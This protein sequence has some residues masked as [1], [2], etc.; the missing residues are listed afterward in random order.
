ML[1]EHSARVTVQKVIEIG[2]ELGLQVV[3]E[4]VESKEQLL[5][6]QSHNCDIAQG[7]YFSK[8]VPVGEIEHW[9]LSSQ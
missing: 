7:Y 5:F 8:P 3:A 1:T 4:G 9:I 6:L 2:H